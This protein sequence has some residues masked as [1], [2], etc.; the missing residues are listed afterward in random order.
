MK[1]RC[2]RRTLG[3]VTALA[4]VS[5]AAAQ[6][7]VASAEPMTPSSV[8]EVNHLM[9]RLGAGAP[10]RLRDEAAQLRAAA[11]S[12]SFAA[13]VHALGAS[14][15]VEVPPLEA[16]A[17]VDGGIGDAI[18]GLQRAVAEARSMI[19]RPSAR[20]LERAAE[21]AH[22]VV[23]RAARRALPTQGSA[24]S[25]LIRA[26][27]LLAEASGALQRM[28]PRSVEGV[29]DALPNF[30]R[31][32][33][34]DLRARRAAALVGDALDTYMQQLLAYAPPP[35]GQHVKGCDVVDQQPVLCVGSE[36]DNDYKDERSQ[37]T[38]DLGGDDTYANAPGTALISP[39]AIN[40]DLG[41]DDTYEGKQIDG[42]GSDASVGGIGVAALG[43]VGWIVDQAGE[44]SYIVET[45]RWKEPAGGQTAQTALG[46]GLAVGGGVGLITDLAG[47]DIYEATTKGGPDA[48]GAVDA[49]GVALLGGIGAIVDAG[50]SDD[51]YSVGPGT[52]VEILGN[53]FGSRAII[54][55]Q[56]AVLFGGT[57][58]I[59][60]QGGQDSFAATASIKL[61]EPTAPDLAIALK[62]VPMASITAQAVGAGGG[63]GLLVTGEG[64]TSFVARIADV[65]WRT[66][67]SL[68]AQGVGIAGGDSIVDDA[69]GDDSYEVSVSTTYRP[70]IEVAPECGCKSPLIF[71]GLGAVYVPPRAEGQGV[72]VV[73]T[74]VLDDAG[75]DDDYLLSNDYELALTFEDRTTASAQAIMLGEPMP[76]VMGQGVGAT[77]VSHGG[78]LMID[79]GGSDT[80]ELRS[81]NEVSGRSL[82]RKDGRADVYYGLTVSSPSD[83]QFASKGAGVVM[84]GQG[85]VQGP[86]V[87]GVIDGF[88]LDLGGSG[89]SFVASET[90]DVKAL[91]SGTVRKADYPWPMVQGGLIALGDDPTI[92]SHPSMP[93]AADSPGAR[94][95]GT[96]LA[97]CNEGEDPDHQPFDFGS[98][99]GFAPLAA[100]TATKISI[101]PP[102]PSEI[103]ADERGQTFFP[104]AA[105]LVD[106]AGKPIAGAPVRF[107]LQV[108]EAVEGQRTSSF[109]NAW[110]AQATTD[111]KGRAT[112]KLPAWITF[113]T[114]DDLVPDADLIFRITATYDGTA[115][116]YPSHGAQAV[117]VSTNSRSRKTAFGGPQPL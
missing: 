112:S 1:G 15:A 56:A 115:E 76:L 82:G 28:R 26:V 51:D 107:D 4:V 58:A 88:L 38:I 108:A 114:G 86:Y 113:R 78:G 43:G 116:R 104:V 6:W 84:T 24:A 32:E 117:H 67:A 85:I 33:A 18:S 41:G 62:S 14:T 49:Q 103:P 19:R 66:A 22:R 47:S 36:A 59:V 69:G 29:V 74:G 35:T 55:G 57:G 111:G 98:G 100:G 71:N 75:G 96:W 31:L 44:D 65:G 2:L 12:R 23:T 40:V 50:S 10:G 53:D 11:A 39:M 64:P 89:D 42:L 68:D 30:P 109:R 79:R 94:G 95:F 48:F 3:I 77:F 61:A 80:Y 110:T 7:P 27:H 81:H 13:I 5:M 17:R 20:V 87:S 70:K 8:A 46:E 45:P 105:T 52:S 9:D 73:G 16:D 34:A 60:D 83:Q 63:T 99:S 21:R 37:L 25:P 72:G 106:D 101:E 93:V 90:S 97:C 102:T 91:P 92:L 54:T